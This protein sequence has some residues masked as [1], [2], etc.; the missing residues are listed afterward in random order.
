MGRDDEDIMRAIGRLEGTVE[1]GFA[2]INSHIDGVSGKADRIERKV[3]AHIVT[4]EAHGSKAERRGA[5]AVVAVIS[6]LVTCV[7]LI[8]GLAKLGL[9][10]AVA[11]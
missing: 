9:L 2:A 1:Q 7:A 6:A 10:R 4:D 5:G 11:Q 3:D 8:A